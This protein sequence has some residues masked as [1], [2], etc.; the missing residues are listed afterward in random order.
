MC[1][2]ISLCE[3]AAGGGR[4]FIEVARLDADVPPARGPRSVPAAGGGA[5]L[6]RLARRFLT[7]PLLLHRWES[8]QLRMWEV[9]FG[10]L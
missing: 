5:P 4:R 7:E 1:L 2:E 6:L 8:E 9:Y 3:L 10:L